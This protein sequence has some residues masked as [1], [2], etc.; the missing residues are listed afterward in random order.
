[1]QGV[2]NSIQLNEKGQ[3]IGCVLS[4]GE[5]YYFDSRYL[6]SGDMS[7]FSVGDA[8]SFEP[9]VHALDSEKKFAC[10]V[11][12][13]KRCIGKITSYNN[14]RGFGYIDKNKFFHISN[15]ISPINISIAT[16]RYTYEV[17]YIE[18]ESNKVAGKM[19]AEQIS[20][21]GITPITD[22]E[23]EKVAEIKE[24]DINYGYII[25]YMPTKKCGYIVSES[26]YPESKR[27]DFYFHATNI[28][29]YKNLNTYENHYR[30]SFTVNRTNPEIAE[31][32][33]ILEVVPNDKKNASNA[34]HLSA[35]EP[36]KITNYGAAEENETCCGYIVLYMPLKKGGYIVRESEYPE[37]KRGN[38][39]FAAQSIDGYDNLNTYEN[40]Y[41]VSY[42][43]NKTN[44]LNAENVKILEVVPQVKNFTF[45]ITGTRPEDIAK[46][47]FIEGETI[48]IKTKT[49][50]KI[51]GIFS[52]KDDEVIVVDAGS[53]RKEIIIE[54]IS[55]LFFC[56]V[57]TSFNILSSSGKI[58]DKYSF[59]LTN[60]INKQLAHLLKLGA[61]QNFICLYSLIVDDSITY[62]NTVDYISKEFL[63]QLQWQRGKI[64]GLYEKGNYFSVD[65]KYR[66]YESTVIDNT[67]S[68]F[69]R[70]G[71]FLNQEVFYKYITHR[72][73][74]ARRKGNI[75]FSIVDIRSR[76][77]VG[78]VLMQAGKS[79]A[80]IQCGSQIYTF[81][82]DVS[83]FNDSDRLK[84]ELLCEGCNSENIISFDSE[85]YQLPSYNQKIQREKYAFDAKVKQA[86]ENGDYL[87]QIELNEE[88]LESE[89]IYP[90]KAVGTIFQICV[91][92]DDIARI[93]QIIEKYGYLLMK[94]SLYGF[95][96]QI[97]MLK[98]EKDDA[99][100]YA[101]AYFTNNGKDE[102]LSSVAS[103]I[104]Q[105][106]I[107][108]NN[109]KD[110]IL[111]KSEMI[112][113]GKIG[114]FDNKTKCGNIIYGN[115]KLNFS[116]K[117]VEDYSDDIIDTKNYTY[118]VSFSVDRSKTIP[119][120][121]NVKI[122]DKYAADPSADEVNIYSD[123]NINFDDVFGNIKVTNLLGFRRD[124]YNL[125]SIIGFLRREDQRKI[126]D[127]RFTG[128]P[129][130]A[131]AVVSYLE[132]LSRNDV[133]NQQKMPAS[134]R[135][136]ALLAAAK[137]HHQIYG[138]GEIAEDSG[139]SRKSDKILF[140]YAV[141]HLSRG[142]VTEIAEVEYYCESVFQNEIADHIK[143]RMIARCIASYFEGTERL[144]VNGCA[145][146]GSIVSVFKRKCNDLKNLSILL[147]NL[148]EAIFDDLVSRKN[149]YIS[150]ELLSKIANKILKMNNIED[151]TD[152]DPCEIVKTYYDSYHRN[153]EELNQGLFSVKR[154]TDDVLRLSELLEEANSSI[155]KY[156]FE[157]E[158]K[159][160]N[161]TVKTFGD[162][163]S[164]LAIEEI[165]KKVSGLKYEFGRIKSIRDD[166][167]EH[168]SRFTFE[169]LRRLLIF[170][171]DIIVDH[172]DK[173]YGQFSPELTV[174]HYLLSDDGMNE[175]V[176]VNNAAG[177]LSAYNV[178]LE[179][180]KPYADSKDFVVDIGGAR[181][182]KE[183]TKTVLGGGAK[184]VNIPI[185]INPSAGDILELSFDI[186]YEYISGFNKDKVIEERCEEIIENCK[187][188]MPLNSISA[189][190]LSDGDNKYSSFAGGKVM[191]P[192]ET[193]AKEMFFGRED[194]IDAVYNMIVGSDNK[195]Q[196][197]SIVAIYGQKRC[198]KTSVMHFLREKIENTIPKA[199][200]IDINIQS[201][202]ADKEK[203]LKKIL[204]KI[205]SGFNNKLRE[206]RFDE[207]RA[208][209]DAQG[210][211]TLGLMDVISD[212]G[213]MIFNDFF[214][215]FRSLF[216]D[217]PVVLM[218]DE[219]TQ[220]Y[221]HMK[222]HA[223][224][225]DFLNL[226]RAMIQDNGFVNIIVGQDFM[227]K[228][229]TDKEV[230]S[231]NFGGSVNGLGTANRKR[232]SY[233]SGDAARK[234]I[235]DPIRFKNGESRYRGVLGQEAA[236]MIY[237]LTGGS[238]FYLMKFC[239]ALVDYMIQNK[240]PFVYED[241]VRN[242]ANGYAFDTKNNPITETD[243][244]PIFNEYS[245]SESDESQ[246]DPD[247]IKQVGY[248]VEVTKK[249]LKQIADLSNSKGVCNL[250]KIVWKN[251][252]E[253]DHIL[254]SLLVRGVLVDPQGN[255][256]VKNN[257]ESL[258]VKIKVG[259]F[260]V[261]LKKRG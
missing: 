16:S 52:H 217:Y 48:V 28:E 40:H 25:L 184:T 99:V 168:P 192:E 218:A 114:L 203:F 207:L 57:V 260:S 196:S 219:F 64:Q 93:E 257:I 202:E 89:M 67:V 86:K 32:I 53:E 198:G 238:A 12:K 102:F 164:N 14:Q 85:D 130:E 19:C 79:L 247:S 153:I 134:K 187:I 220:I 31:N 237:D 62:I 30:V 250:S 74:D 251:N 144:D 46:F 125:E 33:K 142:G 129:E 172:L 213:D 71:D 227:D 200:V 149:P 5:S 97:A 155:G 145:E 242:V 244:D 224:N 108:E 221:I 88:F 38:I 195:L 58:N 131:D 229:V 100:Q 206:D 112:L 143:Y 80:S 104:I 70:N 106:I 177:R 245:Y 50:D 152:E 212:F 186:S 41:K 170:V 68:T 133:S 209:M 159:I 101:N 183:N 178:K 162:I 37:T 45:D 81:S 13:E 201:I 185:R 126:V 235:E 60:V 15:I 252:D 44:P 17:E 49:A 225:E 24:S 157:S 141:K 78:K 228:F 128:T 226:W 23:S 66:C 84:V 173:L 254:R 204:A 232:L 165:E 127:G 179:N 231:Q 258:D 169:F 175:I 35:D 11:K 205:I 188:Q 248:E 22:D 59:R 120:A 115:Q 9:M 197:G 261:W 110:F 163:V 154:T 82:K 21:L 243:F 208:M 113:I 234:M 214:C 63:G 20:V 26:K 76:Y 90:E 256:I 147:L 230:T 171:G 246:T 72:T 180:I 6:S 95:L 139:N 8:V 56:G 241:L 215:T 98:N 190:L 181:I 236:S 189:E 103:G 1:M 140:N 121:C 137:I 94:C 69:V 92:H 27:G 39:Y 136:D 105:N 233:L 167:E 216:K 193:D 223:I 117:D 61:N 132:K 210:L 146:R 83:G 51:V 166:I 4:N 77:Q 111:G 3:K 148:P 7:D 107:N 75:S 158:Q 150:D 47:D 54:D 138:N 249:I 55:E 18:V 91:R 10:G 240:I 182:I 42:T 109:I 119:K 259:L 156:L 135:A 34:E 116:H 174:E 65:K 36:E 199:I 96:M 194:D 161:E 239:N 87:R 151:N 191:K 2:I 123:I 176:E 160:L 43:V 211:K 124:N 122:M 222:N 253:K 73:V 29:G 118:S 255:D